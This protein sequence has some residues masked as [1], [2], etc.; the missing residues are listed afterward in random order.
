[1]NSLER[2]LAAQA[3]P[4][5]AAPLDLD[6]LRQQAQLAANDL[7]ALIAAAGQAGHGRPGRDA[8]VTELTDLL[9]RV[10]SFSRLL[11]IRPAEKE[12]RQSF[13]TA[14]RQMWRVE[15]RV[16]RLEWR[17]PLRAPGTSSRSR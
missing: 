17:T 3:G 5:P 15:S 13:R 16:I 7:V 2:T 11:S 6:S 9:D 10:Q 1:M 8:I 12:V 14:T 4:A